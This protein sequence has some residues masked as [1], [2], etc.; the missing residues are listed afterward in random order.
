MA[1][2]SMRGKRDEEEMLMRPGE[3]M[4]LPW[5]IAPNRWAGY[6]ILKDKNYSP[7]QNIE[8]RIARSIIVGLNIK[9][10]I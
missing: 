10:V 1:A 3:M 2:D 4:L 5:E 9:A 7:W 6:D 8:I